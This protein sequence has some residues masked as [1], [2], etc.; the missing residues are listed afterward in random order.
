M[1]P[2]L[3]KLT[4]PITPSY[5]IGLPSFRSFS[6]FSNSALPAWIGSPPAATT[7]GIA[8]LIAALSALPALAMASA[9]MAPAS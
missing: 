3:S 5:L 6:A 2:Y 8:A 1:S 9:T 7:S 4:L